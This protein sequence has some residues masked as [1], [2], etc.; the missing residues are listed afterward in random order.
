MKSL[1]IDLIHY[2]YISNIYF[3]NSS[4]DWLR[5][6]KWFLLYNSDH[7]YF[8]VPR[9]IHGLMYQS[10]YRSLLDRLSTNMRPT[11]RST[12]DWESTNVLVKLPLMSAEVSMVTILVAY[13]STTGNYW[14]DIGQLSTELTVV[15]HFDSWVRVHQL[16]QLIG[17]SR[18]WNSS[19][20]WSGL[21]SR[22]VASHRVN[23]MHLSP[24]LR[25][26]QEKLL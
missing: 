19:V 13:R 20:L 7:G 10:I 12:V 3:K 24:L 15:Y 6:K 1:G 8:R 22:V 21:V 14:R 17:K 18:A 9:L 25:N 26:A 16:L 4:S 23:L 2:M 5:S 11:C